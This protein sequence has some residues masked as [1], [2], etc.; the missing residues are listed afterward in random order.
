MLSFSEKIEIVGVNLYV[1]L[2]ENILLALFKEFGKNKGPIPIKG[3]INGKDFIQTLVKYKGIWRLY[4][5]S[6]MLK[7]TKLKVGDMV[8]FAIAIDRSSREI[9]MPIKFK[10]ALEKNKKA[11]EAFKKFPPS[12][13]KEINRYLGFIKSEETLHKNIDRIV[14]YLAGEKVEYHV[15][16]RN[17]K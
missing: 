5:N 6:I 16:L 10:Q 2:P 11:F 12:R 1:L 8:E 9:P 13:Q 17:K 4:V 7:G 14:R 3:T 15:L